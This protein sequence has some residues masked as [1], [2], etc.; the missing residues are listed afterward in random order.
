[1]NQSSV[2]DESAVGYAALSEGKL[3]HCNNNDRQAASGFLLYV[4]GKVPA[5]TYDVRI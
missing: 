4:L 1:M 2:T 3:S 5:F